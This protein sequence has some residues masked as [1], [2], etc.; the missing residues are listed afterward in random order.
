MTTPLDT[1]L[2]PALLDAIER[3][4][5]DEVRTRRDRCQGAENGLSYVR[6]LAQGRLDIVGREMEHRRTGADPGDLSS[7]VEELPE[8]LA[9]RMRGPGLGRPPQ[10]LEPHD[11]PED[12]LSELDG[13]A[14]PTRLGGLAGADDDDVADLVASLEAFEQT[15]SG[16]RRQL[17]GQID[18]L[19][20][21]ITRRYRTGEASVESLLA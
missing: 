6:R 8:I 10:D 19:Q 18:A 11:I 9:D 5:L 13:I 1:L 15:V 17:H 3:V 20:A 4:P 12:M 21:E 14:G 7:L 2:D 16:L